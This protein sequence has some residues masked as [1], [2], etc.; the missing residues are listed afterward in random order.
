MS[1]SFQCEDCTLDE[2]EINSYD[3]TEFASIVDLLAE[4]HID[5][6]QAE[7][8]MD[9]K[10]LLFEHLKQRDNPDGAQS[11]V[12]HVLQDLKCTRNLSA[13]N[14]LVK[15]LFEA[16]F[17]FGGGGGGSVKVGAVCMYLGA[18]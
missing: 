8:T 11:V 6:D 4:H 18:M 1:G 10:N 16:K 15:I 14:L 12:S 17:G 13:R 3:A 9:A 7:N 2:E 5:A